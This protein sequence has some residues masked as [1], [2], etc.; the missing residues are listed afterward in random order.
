MPR[1]VPT[2][3]PPI[4]LPSTA[5]G[6][7]T[8]PMTLTTPITATTIPKAG[9]ASRPWRPHGRRLDLVMVGL[10]FDIHQVL[11]L[12]GVEVAAHHH[13]QIVGNELHDVVVA[14]NARVLGE[15]RAVL[16]VL[17]VVLDR[18]QAFLAHLGQDL[19]QHGQQIDVQRLG[20]LRALEDPGQARRLS[21]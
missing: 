9:T 10:D 21:P 15:D 12:D 14:G 2:S 5:G 16:G 11:D 20:V 4:I 1:K 19:E 6:A 8:E 18:H 3:A 13:A 17:D 7:P